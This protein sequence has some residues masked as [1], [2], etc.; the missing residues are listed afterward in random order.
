MKLKELKKQQKSELEKTLLDLQKE[1]VKINSQ[2]STK[3]TL[4]N[5]GQKKSIKKTIARIKTLL[6][7]KEENHS[8]K[9]ETTAKK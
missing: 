5:P 9:N 2:I 4:Q 1:L 8:T 7:Q 6:S 3:T